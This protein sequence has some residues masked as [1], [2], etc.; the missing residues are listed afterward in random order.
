MERFTYA[1]IVS[2]PTRSEVRKR[3]AHT[4]S[5]QQQM[6]DSET[7][8]YLWM[9][10]ESFGEA[11]KASMN[12]YC[13]YKWGEVIADWRRSLSNYPWGRGFVTEIDQF[14]VAKV[15]S[16]AY[17]SELLWVAMRLKRC[18]IVDNLINLHEHSPYLD[19]T[20]ALSALTEKTL[21]VLHKLLGY[22]LPGKA[23]KCLIP[24]L[25]EAWLLPH[26]FIWLSNTFSSYALAKYCSL[27][28]LEWLKNMGMPLFAERQLLHAHKNE[29]VMYSWCQTR[30]K[31]LI[32]LGSVDPELIRLVAQGSSDVAKVCQKLL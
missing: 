28:G 31:T 6:W 14:L 17:A 4:R 13:D 8:Y 21:P 22:V 9:Y 19:V 15:T 32:R 29:E 25:T 26:T 11:I 24:W 18:D 3:Y 5:D 16:T 12:L 20:D 7:P 23:S 2:A 30:L 10:C 1:E 27:D